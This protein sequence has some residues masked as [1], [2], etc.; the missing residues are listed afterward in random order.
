VNLIYYFFSYKLEC[1]VGATQIVYEK[2][3]IELGN[4]KYGVIT[5]LLMRFEGVRPHLN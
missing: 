2:V 1:Y 5:Y 4:T 3:A